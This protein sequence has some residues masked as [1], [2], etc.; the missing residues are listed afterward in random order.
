MS[1]LSKGEFGTAEA[2]LHQYE[3]YTSGVMAEFATGGIFD[4]ESLTCDRELFGPALEDHLHAITIHAAETGESS[5]LNSAIE[6]QVN[7]GKQGMQMVSWNPVPG[8]SLGGLRRTTIETPV[9]SEDY[10]TFNRASPASADLMLQQTNFEQD[11]VLLSG[12]NLIRGRL[13]NTLHQS[14]EPRWHTNALREFFED[15]REAH[16]S[17]LEKIAEGPR[18]TE[19]DLEKDPYTEDMPAVTLVN[20]V[21]YSWEAILEASTTFLRFRIEEGFYPATEGNYRSE[22]ED[23]VVSAADIGATDHSIRL[24]QTLIEMA[25]IENIHR[26]Y[27]QPGSQIF[28]NQDISDTEIL[29]WVGKLRG[30]HKRT[31]DSILSTAFENI[32]KYEYQRGP[33]RIRVIGADNQV[34]DEYYF[35]K[36]PFTEFRSLNTR[37]EFPELVQELRDRS[38]NGFIEPHE[39][40][41]IQP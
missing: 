7:L 38:L 31:T 26:P 35:T 23:L 1:A 13:T 12:K 11:R 32:L 24:C 36:L 14:P 15:L 2:A 30:I 29:H 8:Q 5:I 41:G 27:E 6:A 17:S 18:F 10:I 4:D 40:V 19:I 3:R 21:K 34:E 20:Q 22:W 39:G 28:G 37:R 9:T 16:K 33:D 25:F